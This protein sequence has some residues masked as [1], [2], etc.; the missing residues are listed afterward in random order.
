MRNVCSLILFSLLLTACPPD[1]VVINVPDVHPS[2]TVTPVPLVKFQ[3]PVVDSFDYKVDPVTGVGYLL[4][5]VRSG[6]FLRQFK[7]GELSPPDLVTNT[8]Y[9][10]DIRFMPPKIA[11]SDDSIYVAW[12]GRAKKDPVT[13]LLSNGI[14]ITGR[15]KTGASWTTPK[16]LLKDYQFEFFNIVCSGHDLYTA[17]FSLTPFEGVIVLK[18][19]DETRAAE[20]PKLLVKDLYHLDAGDEQ[21]LFGR[22]KTISIIRVKNGSVTV[23][24]RKEYFPVPQ[25][26]KTGVDS[27]LIC[28]WTDF[29]SAPKP[30]KPSETDYWPTALGCDDSGKGLYKVS[31][32]EM[33]KEQA[34]VVG[35]RAGVSMLGGTPSLVYDLDSQL[36]ILDMTTGKDFVLGPGTDPLVVNIGSQRTDIVTSS[37]FYSAQ[38]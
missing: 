38:H 34:L 23:E 12:S 33:S 6:I 2:P 30:D 20:F 26:V 16:Q 9:T 7:N 10:T 8:F 32:I 19:V 13:K 24:K 28:G 27:W 21:L 5:S 15:A 18:G 17:L 37:M 31:T 11:I 1:P 35:P 25:A 22:F 3:F 36:H 4:T 29:K 14:F